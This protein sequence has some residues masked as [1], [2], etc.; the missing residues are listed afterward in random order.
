MEY[1]YLLLVVWNIVARSK[2]RLYKNK[3]KFII[4]K[5]CFNPLCSALR[6]NCRLFLFFHFINLERLTY[7][8]KVMLLQDGL[9]LHTKFNQNPTYSAIT[10]TTF[11]KLWPP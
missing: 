4:S 8:N 5:I 9:N 6:L 11:R 1:W 2:I 10:N 7:K 3:K